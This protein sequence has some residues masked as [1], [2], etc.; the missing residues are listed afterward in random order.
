MC[1]AG[2]LF[3]GIFARGEGAQ[4]VS[5]DAWLQ[6]LLDVEGALARAAARAGRIPQDHADAITAT[7]DAGRF[8]SR[9]LGADAARS[10]TPV[11]PLVR[12]LSAAV[13]EDAAGSVHLGATS[14][15]ILDSAMMLLAA[16]SLDA[17]LRDL[18]AA[19]SAA[20]G[21][22]EQHRG[23]LMVGRT[24]LQQALPV[25][26]GLKA[27]GWIV[28][29]DEAAQRLCEV[30]T[31]TLAVQ[32]GG[33]AGT[34]ASLGEA[35]PDM[36]GY[37]AEELELAEPTLPW[38]T[39]RTR[40][41]DLAGAL[42]LA[43]GAVGKIAGDVVLLAQTEVG[44]VREGGTE[45]RGGSSA[46]PQKWNPVA[47]VSAAACAG[48]APGLVST[49]LSA[50]TR[51]EHER[52]AG[53]WQAEWPAMTRLLQAV[54]SAAA[55]L[56]DC[57]QYLE[58]DADR[59]T[60]NLRGAGDLILAE[61]VMAALAGPL[62]RL[63][64]HDLVRQAAGAAVREGTDL[65]RQLSQL[66]QVCQHLTFDDLTALLDPSTYLGSADA[67]IGRSLHRR[68]RAPSGWRHL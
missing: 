49:L 33:A 51:Q 9:E 26:F 57:L 65:K 22:A 21:L 42:G 8:N 16:R 20:A 63:T 52:A 44:E 53:G 28:A 46:L 34:L 27:A 48:Q 60:A 3:D 54:G 30:R 66:E 14:Q 43:A 58:V 55:W 37:F 12:A 47:A 64:A 24:L 4:C 38:H 10:A 29:L 39:N 62:G 45:D 18:D 50:T 11:V 61:R 67:F 25:T 5:G 31:G 36:L 32:L 56:A 41:A 2:G 15:D 40:M 13:P 59:M 35:G 23:T 7:C 6:A 68:G 1:E 17:Q 19:A